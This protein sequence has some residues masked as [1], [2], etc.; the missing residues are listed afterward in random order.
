[1]ENEY[2]K[3]NEH[4]WRV[5]ERLVRDF[6]PAA[7]LHTGRGAI[8]PARLSLHIL[9]STRY[10]MQ[11]PS[12]VGFSSGKNFECDW[13]A[14]PDGDLP[15]REDILDCIEEMKDISKRWLCEMN[16]DAENIAFPWAGKTSTGVVIFMLRHSLFHIGELSSLLN[17]S[18]NGVVDDHYVLA[19]QG[20]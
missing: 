11:A 5:F 2:V 4:T 8:T 9:Q 6:D 15:S 16:L 10:Y 18:K 13:V 12:P 7:W 1:M 17:E 3:Q 19:L 20:M 14:T